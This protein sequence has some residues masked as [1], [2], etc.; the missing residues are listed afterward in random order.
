[1]W[2]L[3]TADVP[4]DAS[5]AISVLFGIVT[6]VASLAG[7]LL[8]LVNRRPQ[9]PAKP[10]PSSSAPVPNPVVLKR[11]LSVISPW[12]SVMART[13]DFGSGKIEVYHAIEQADYIAILAVT[14]NFLIPIVRQYRPAL[15]RFTWELPAGMVDPGED[16]AETCARELREETGLKARRIHALGS[17]AADSARLGNSIHSY[18][19]ETEDAD[20]LPEPEP[21]IIVQLVSLERLIALIV[22]GEFDL[23]LHVATVGVALMQPSFARLLM[24]SPS[25]REI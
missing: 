20:G 15:E 10:P 18:L 5:L 2:L 19:V 21:G 23:Q 13:V 6:T 1:V 16:P 22:S 14:P 17:H 8:W 24:A 25:S 7:G 4:P 12:V 11:R 9:T 3:G